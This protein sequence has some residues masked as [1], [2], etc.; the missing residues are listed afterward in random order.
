M[1]TSPNRRRGD[2]LEQAI[3]NAAYELLSTHRYQEV[4]LSKI[5]AAANTSRSVLYRHW[6]N[7]FE[8]MFAAMHNHLRQ[9]NATLPNFEF[10][11]GNLRANVIYTGVQF[12]QI[13]NSMLP[14]FQHMMIAEMHNHPKA[15]HKLLIDMTTGN[16][17]MMAYVIKLAQRTGELTHQPSDNAQLALFQLI[18]YRFMVEDQSLTTDD[19]TQLVDDVVMPALLAH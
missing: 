15:I 4:T 17:A 9:T 18:R 8:I 14:E 3:Y 2:D 5:A 12:N 6:D 11:K 16:L 7:A 13:R 1:T 10:D 19:I